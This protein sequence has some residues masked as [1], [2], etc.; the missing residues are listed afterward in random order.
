MSSVLPP[1]NTTGIMTTPPTMVAAYAVGIENQPVPTM[2]QFTPQFPPLEP[3]QPLDLFSF[4]GVD[5]PKLSK[6]VADTL[7]ELVKSGEIQLATT[8]KGLQRELVKVRKDRDRFRAGFKKAAQLQKE[9]AALYT[10]NILLS[11]C[12]DSI[13]D[14]LK[15]TEMWKE[16][17]EHALNRTLMHGRRG[18]AAEEQ[19]RLNAATVLAAVQ[20][21]D[22]KIA[23]RQERHEKR[24]KAQERK[25][26]EKER[27]KRATARK[28]AKA[29]KEKRAEPVKVNVW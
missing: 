20:A 18:D 26:W 1:D 14:M 29:K 24:A 10:E 12:Y 16:K 15:E 9:K 4:F 13:E 8:A 7:K 5:R 3:A 6:L 25:R 11:T 27:V 22:A 21:W 17:L 19:D 28:A 23:L 2:P